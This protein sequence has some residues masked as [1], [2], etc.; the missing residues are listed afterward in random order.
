[1][2]RPF[3]GRE[4]GPAWQTA[5]ISSWK[6]AGFRSIVSLNTAD[7]ITTLC[8][9]FAQDITFVELPLN[10]TRALV[11]DLLRAAALSNSAISGIINADV[12]IAPHSAIIQHLTE[13]MNGL[14]IAERIGLSRYT[15]HPTG[16]PGMGFDAFFFK[17]DAI[18]RLKIDE[19]WRIGD[20]WWDYWLPLEFQA[21]GFEINTFPSPIL[22]HI[23]H[24]QSWNWY[25]AQ[26]SFPPLLDFLRTS[27]LRHPDLVSAI[28]TMPEEYE[29]K[30]ILALA[31][32][33]YAW[34][35]S[36][37]SLWRPEAGSVDDLLTQLL[38]ALWI[39]PPPPVA[40]RGRVMLRRL[41]NRLHLHRAIELLG[42]R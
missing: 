10:R 7:E 41:I 42:L 20:T 16:L 34:L 40:G 21:A 4:F 19:R 2:S 6:A 8:S 36:R 1:M 39:S 17:T 23:D 32:K 22:L 12:L 37:T 15:L 3:S 31:S 11:A 38:Y 26:Q 18:A 14:A 33:I 35:R 30:H 28:D 27:D 25:T 13:D 24:E 5:C 29:A 9:R